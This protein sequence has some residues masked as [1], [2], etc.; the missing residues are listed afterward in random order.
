MNTKI[1]RIYKIRIKGQT[2]RQIFHGSSRILAFGGEELIILKEEKNS[3]RSLD[4]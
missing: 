4:N 2:L 1:K 3:L